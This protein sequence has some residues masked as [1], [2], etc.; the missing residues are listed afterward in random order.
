MTSL[1]PELAAAVPSDVQLDGELV[2]FDADGKPDF[3]R[4]S[5]R[6]LHRRDGISVTYKVFDVLAF[7]GESTLREPYRAR[8]ELLEALTFDGVRTRVVPTF[9]DG[10]ALFAAVCE[11][12]LEGVVAKRE[13]DSYRPGERLWVKTKNRQTARFAEEHRFARC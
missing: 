3:H 10:E 6:T 9:S 8:R 1:L 13:R 12:R 4:L 5:E 2:A 11:W 7:D